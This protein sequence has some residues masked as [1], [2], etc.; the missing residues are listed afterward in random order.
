MTNPTMTNPNPSPSSKIPE[1]RSG[2]WSVERFVV[3]DAD[4]KF[5]NFRCAFQPGMSHRM[6]DPGSYT[7]LRYNRQIVM[8]D[9]PA[10]IFDL[11]EVQQQARGHILLNGLGLGLALQ[12]VLDKPEVLTVTIIEISSD[13]IALISPSF[14]DPRVQ[15]I[16][17]DAYKW[18][19][20]KKCIYD[21]VWHDIWSGICFDNLVGMK[22]LHRRYGRRSRWQ[23]SWCR[24]LCGI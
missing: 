6:L 19:P 11:Y 12:M 17:A 10:E 1:G 18:Q 8:S 9:T 15:I 21:V 5:H 13:V 3:S 22:R 24:H 16:E 20:P 7:Q 14:E 2:E 23:G 4:A